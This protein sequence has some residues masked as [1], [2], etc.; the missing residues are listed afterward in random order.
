VLQ[1]NIKR[2]LDRINVSFDSHLLVAQCLAR[3][4]VGRGKLVEALLVR[5][6]PIFQI[7]D[8]GKEL[9]LSVLMLLL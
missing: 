8:L 5:L 7:R 3:P 1:S 9:A 4:G 6:G 2:S